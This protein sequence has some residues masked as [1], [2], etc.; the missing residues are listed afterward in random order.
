MIRHQKRSVRGAAFTLIELLVVIAIIGILIGLLLP[1][2]QKIR[3]SANRLSCQ[4][5][6]KQIGLAFHNHHDQVRYFP[7]GGWFPYTAPNYVQG[8][9]AIGADQHA[10]WGFQILPFMEGDNVWKGGQA[11]NDVDRALVA[12]GTPNPLF[13]CPS[14]RSPQ[15]VTYKDNYLPALNGGPV[16]HALCDYAASNKDGTGVIQQFKPTRIAD[17]T[18]GTSQTL[19]VGEKRL[20]LLYL[21]TKQT[22]DNQG[23]TAGYNLDTVRKTS[24]PPAQDYSAPTGD[25]LSMF[26]S[27]HPGR[28]NALFAD[29]SVRPISYSIDRLTFSLLGNKSDGQ[30]IPSVDDF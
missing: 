26:G 12:I 15:T 8:R 22:D 21:G 19:M 24:R 11:T 1:A 30:V 2:V 9:P 17:I 5:N 29:G 3:E 6:L 7:S 4:N 16:I 13:F 27:S 23:Y 20:N 10:G 14:R 18:D 28:F 25:G